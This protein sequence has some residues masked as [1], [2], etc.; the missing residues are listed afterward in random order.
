MGYS[1]PG[2]YVAATGKQRFE[3]SP[4]TAWNPEIPR[5]PAGVRERSGHEVGPRA[6]LIHCVSVQPIGYKGIVPLYTSISQIYTQENCSFLCNL[7][8]EARQESVL[9]DPCLGLL[10]VWR[11]LKG[12]GQSRTAA[13]L[14]GNVIPGS[15]RSGGWIQFQPGHQESATQSPGRV[16]DMA[17]EAS[18][19][20]SSHAFT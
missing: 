8:V 17:V 13:G 6:Y 9:R 5:A 10:Q 3:I 18:F 16:C 19:F 2:L 20:T 7:K 1:R 12:D 14:M 11:L 15:G 4:E